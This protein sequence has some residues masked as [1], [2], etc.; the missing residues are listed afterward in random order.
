MT[1]SGVVSEPRLSPETRG[2]GRLNAAA[3]IVRAPGGT[4]DAFADEGLF[5]RSGGGEAPSPYSEGPRYGGLWG[6]GEIECG[7]WSLLGPGG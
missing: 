6:I 4:G 3:E 2:G 5:D 7:S 1:D